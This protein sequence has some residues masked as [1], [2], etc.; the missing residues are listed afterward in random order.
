MKGQE[1]KVNVYVNAVACAIGSGTV[2]K[3][4]S[5]QYAF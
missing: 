2:C 4:L 3:V 5:F 1:G